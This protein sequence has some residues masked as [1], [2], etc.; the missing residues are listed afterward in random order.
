MTNSNNIEK[1][2][3]YRLPSGQMVEVCGVVKVI[4]PATF[5]HEVT[6]RYL[7]ADGAM[8]PNDFQLSLEFLQTRSERVRVAPPVVA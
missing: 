3:W 1:G 2:Q 8:S 6:L 5:T 4:V 7:D